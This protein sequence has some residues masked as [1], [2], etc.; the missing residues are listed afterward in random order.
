MALLASLR[1]AAELCQTLS[2]RRRGYDPSDE[3]DPLHARDELRAATS[4]LREILVQ[5][6]LSLSVKHGEGVE[7]VRAFEDRMLLARAARALHVVHQHL[8]SLY[9]AVDA[10]LA[11]QAR[12]IQAEAARLAGAGESGFTEA[13]EIWSDRTQPFIEDLLRAAL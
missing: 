3:Q 2:L 8:L 12:I 5:L 7:L 9:P 10:D 1:T 4:E 6:R 11:E 13:A